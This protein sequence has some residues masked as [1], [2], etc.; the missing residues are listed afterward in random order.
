MKASEVLEQAKWKIL[1]D[2]WGKFA[3]ESVT[4]EV[5]IAGAVEAVTGGLEDRKPVEVENKDCQAACYFLAKAT[6]V[7]YPVTYETEGTSIAEWND[8]PERT[9][10]DVLDAFDMAIKLAKEDEALAH[11][12]ST[13]YQDKS[14]RVDV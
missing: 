5:C 14:L 11:A 6:G 7:T 13:T 2:G 9:L 8:A 4:G 1:E 12:P 10:T 3:F